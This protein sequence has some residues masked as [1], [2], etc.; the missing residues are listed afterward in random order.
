MP[1]KKS[2]KPVSSRTKVLEEANASLRKANSYLQDIINSFKQPLQVLEPVFENGEI[3]DFRFKLT[4][5]AYATYA[6][7]VPESI[8]HKRVS[9]IPP[10][11]LTTTS[12]SNVAKTYLS[13]Q[14]DTWMIRYAQDGLDLYNEL[15]AIKMEEAVILHFAD[16]TKLKYLKLELLKKNH[17]AGKL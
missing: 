3:V 4:N 13:G 7:T 15:T 17:R 14:R 16:Y 5:Q 6:N 8:Q 11:Y 12:F 9:E 2:K 10:G 1:E